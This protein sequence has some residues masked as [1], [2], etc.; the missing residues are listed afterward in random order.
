MRQQTRC[1]K[2]DGRWGLAPEV[3]LWPPYADCGLHGH[4]CSPTPTSSQK[5][6]QTQSNF[7]WDFFDLSIIQKCIAQPQRTKDIPGWFLIYFSFWSNSLYYLLLFIICWDVF[8]G[9]ECCFFVI[10]IVSLR[11]YI[12]ILSLS[13]SLP[14]LVCLEFLHLCYLQTLIIFLWIFRLVVAE[15]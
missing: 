13:V 10:N 1:P 4:M 15:S 2:Y 9:S 7:S 6:T 3:V 12:H 11:R 5:K 8:W 14:S